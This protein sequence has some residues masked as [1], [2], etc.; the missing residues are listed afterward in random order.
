MKKFFIARTDVNFR[1]FLTTT[2]PTTLEEAVAL[3]AKFLECGAKN[4]A[5]NGLR[6]VQVAP[7]SPANLV[8]NLNRTQKYMGGSS[9]AYKLVSVEEAVAKFGVTL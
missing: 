6:E 3:N 8:A 7:K 4:A 5:K 2:A 9:K 1:T